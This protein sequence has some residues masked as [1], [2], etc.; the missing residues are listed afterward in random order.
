[1][2]PRPRFHLSDQFPQRP[3]GLFRDASRSSGSGSRVRLADAGFRHVQR[4]RKHGWKPSAAS[5]ASTAS[6]LPL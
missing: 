3:A 6:A 2:R 4:V 1:L 5:A